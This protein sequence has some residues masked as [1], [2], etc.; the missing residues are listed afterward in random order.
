MK[1]IKIWKKENQIGC[2]YCTH[3]MTCE[4]RD[5]K[6]NKAKLG[7]PDW[8]HWED[9]K[10]ICP[11]CGGTGITNTLEIYNSFEYIEAIKCKCIN[12]TPAD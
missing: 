2:G 12:K 5:P 11:E 1:E 3:E 10:D 9:G 7:C 6:I 8:L 4:K